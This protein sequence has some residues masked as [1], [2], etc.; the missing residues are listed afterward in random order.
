MFALLQDAVAVASTEQLSRCYSCSNS[1]KT[2]C[3]ATQSTNCSSTYDGCHSTY[4]VVTNEGVTTESTYSRGCWDDSLF[5]RDLNRACEDGCFR[6]SN[7]VSNA[8]GY[9]CVSCCTGDLCNV[10]AFHESQTQ[11]KSIINFLTLLS[12]QL[13]AAANA[14]LI[15]RCVPVATLTR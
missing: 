6:L 4:M 10:H 9:A 3:E 12:L 13:T 14:L 1:L 5:S 11:S 7:A 15:V 8:V 2:S